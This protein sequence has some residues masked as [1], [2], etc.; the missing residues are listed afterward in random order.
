MRFGR[1][2]GLEFRLVGRRGPVV[3]MLHGYAAP[4]D[5]LVGAAEALAEARLVRVV[6][7]A[8]PVD[9]FGMVRAWFTFDTE[10]HFS[11]MRDDRHEALFDDRPPGLARARARL[12]RCLVDLRARL[13]GPPPVL[14]GFSQ[15]AMM[16]ADLALRTGA[17]LS[18][19]G[20]VCGSGVAAGGWPWLARQR[21]GL[22]TYV[23]HG[24]AD[25]ILPPRLGRTVAGWLDRAGMDVE[26]ELFSGGH[27]IAPAHR[28]LCRLVDRAGQ[29]GPFRRGSNV[30]RR[31]AGHD[32]SG[33]SHPPRLRTAG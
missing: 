6:L 4:A 9:Y 23:G 29:M 17:P 20:L 2:E 19:L 10:A 18:G 25:P 16:A 12:L 21:S 3:V 22:P 24:D 27:G 14:V 33:C 30:R 28:G 11:A 13:G 32:R 5:D 7:P 8:G 15:G 26:L 1:S 31:W